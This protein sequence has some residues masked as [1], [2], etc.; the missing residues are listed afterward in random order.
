[1]F[2]AARASERAF[3]AIFVFQESEMCRGKSSHSISIGN[4]R[5]TTSTIHDEVEQIDNTIRAERI[6]ER[7]THKG[8]LQWSHAGF[9][10]QRRIIFFR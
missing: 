1:M 5:V 10:S 7:A 6:A 8:S 9:E 3:N 4:G 2:N